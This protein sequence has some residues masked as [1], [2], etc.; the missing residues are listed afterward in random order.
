MKNFP[1]REAKLIGKTDEFAYYEMTI[2]PMFARDFLR[3]NEGNRRVSNMHMKHMSLQMQLG[4]WVKTP[5]AL[6]FRKDGNIVDGQHRLEAIVDSEVDQQ[7][8]FAV[9]DH[10]DEIFKILDQG[11]LRTNADILRLP[12]P[13]VQPIQYILRCTG[14]AK[15]VASDILQVAD[16]HLMEA[17]KF[18]HEEIK[19]KTKAVRSAPFRAAFC[20][21]T[22]IGANFNVAAEQYQALGSYSVKDFTPLMTEMMRQFSEG[23]PIQDGRSMNNEWFMRGMFMFLNYNKAQ[24]LRIYGG[25]RNE[26]KQEVNRVVSE[27]KNG[28]W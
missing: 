11:K 28:Q 10:A 2:T 9:A 13:V 19:P 1:P 22:A 25:F 18:I 26:I 15:P 17:S 4:R 20:M 16:S 24:T 7:M 8:I 6:I 5:C 23:F 14:T 21:A 27:W 12:S 3:K